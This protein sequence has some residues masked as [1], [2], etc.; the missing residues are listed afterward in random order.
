MSCTGK[1]AAASDF[2]QFWCLSI[3]LTSPE[4]VSEVDRMLELA[5]SD[6]QSSLAAVGACSCAM[7]E[8]ATRLA[9]KLNIIDAGVVYNCSCGP[10]LSPE[11]RAL[12]LAWLENQYRLIRNQEVDLCGMTGSTF[13]AWASAEQSLTLWSYEQIAINRIMRTGI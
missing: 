4:V 11:A 13:P 10:K 1:Y 12:W 7:P 6:V 3:D 2:D 8:W 5:A 9:K